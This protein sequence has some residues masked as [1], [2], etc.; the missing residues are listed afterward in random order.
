MYK[1][2][3]SL[4]SL[5]G[6]FSPNRY[7]EDCSASASCRLHYMATQAHKHTPQSPT[8]HTERV[9]TLCTSP[10]PQTCWVQQLLTVRTQPQWQW[11]DYQ[12][13]RCPLSPKHTLAAWSYVPLESKHPGQSA[14]KGACQTTQDRSHLSVHVHTHRSQQRHQAC[15]RETLLTP[16]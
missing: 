8:M 2:S 13:R 9:L 3:T 7:R 5:A 11:S 1:D 15:I 6:R 10:G 14:Y 16:S 12:Y 4:W